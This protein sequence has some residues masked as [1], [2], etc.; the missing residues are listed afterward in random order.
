M[1]LRALTFNIRYDTPKDGPNAWSYRRDLVFAQVQ[2]QQCHVIG[3]QE[4][5]AHQRRDLEAGLPGYVWLGQGRDLDSG[6]EQC[7]LAIDP[8]FE[9]LGWG[10]FWLCPTP[11]VPGA[12]GWD[13]ALTRICTWAHLARA[14]V[15]IRVL[16]S[17][18]DHRGQLARL[19]SARLLSSYVAS[20][21]EPVLLLG[22]FNTAPDSEP[23]ALL[24]SALQDS[25]A[26]IHPGCPLGTFHGFGRVPDG[27]RIDYLLASPEFLVVDS[28]ILDQP[29][30]PYPSDHF[31]VYASYELIPR[32]T[33]SRSGHEGGR[34]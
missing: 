3:F 9:I 14:G 1:D 22:D 7:C 30:D 25:Y 12:V 28:R 33:R 21:K 18:W 32:L 16:N 17:H 23:I 26:V 15:E 5:L 4:V 29:G 20:V 13:A 27:Q 8:G 34:T 31:A 10:T 2:R 6:G 11:D 19:E 24:A